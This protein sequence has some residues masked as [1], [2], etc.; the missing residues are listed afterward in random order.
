MPLI[1][2]NVNLRSTDVAIAKEIA[3]KIRSSSGGLSHVKALGF[4]LENRGMVQV[5]M[6]LTDYGITPISIVF[7]EIEKEARERGVEIAE[8]EVVGL[9]PLSA[10]CDATAR[11]LK[12]H[13]FS[14]DQVL[15]RRIWG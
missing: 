13:S 8:S 6:N 5:S 4:K 2:F 10:L 1:A 15:E 14:S 11:Y 12:L 7:E 3:R 9:I